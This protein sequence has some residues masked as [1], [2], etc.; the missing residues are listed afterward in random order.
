MGDSER[1]LHNVGVVFK[2]VV[3]H[4]AGSWIFRDRVNPQASTG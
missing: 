4:K 1:Q 3:R 2:T